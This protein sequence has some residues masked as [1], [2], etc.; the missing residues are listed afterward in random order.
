MKK[1]VLVLSLLIC[2][3][4]ADA[5]WYFKKYQVKDMSQ[6]TRVQ[7]DE[8]LKSSNNGILAGGFCA[9][10][11]GCFLLANK[12]GLWESDRNPS[13]FEQLIGRKTL[14]DIYG[15]VGVGLI[16]GGIIAFVGCLE[17]SKNIKIAIRK[18]YPSLG[19][20]QVLPRVEYNR[21]TA[22]ANLGLTL[23]CHF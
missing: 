4:F 13:D 3:T 15:G 17:R 22:S 1:I 8:S 21:F 9:V 11:G 12:Y 19:L 23:T 18:N 16:A 6:L 14:H 20:L 7:L 10:M 2:T 5:Q